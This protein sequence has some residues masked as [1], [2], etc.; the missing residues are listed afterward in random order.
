MNLSRLE[1]VDGR[2]WGTDGKICRG[3]AEGAPGGLQWQLRGDA[4]RQG[5]CTDQG[6]GTGDPWLRAGALQ[7]AE[8]AHA[9]GLGKGCEGR[10][11]WSQWALPPGCWDLEPWGHGGHL[12][13][14][15]WGSE[16]WRA[17]SGQSVPPPGSRRRPVSVPM[18]LP[19]FYLLGAM[20]LRFIFSFDFSHKKHGLICF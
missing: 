11:T 6:G 1:P 7:G 16:Q 10:D 4:Q 5:L 17:G 15:L 9:A 2:R 14:C 3:S 8:D 13:C 19:F 12:S 20:K 18:E